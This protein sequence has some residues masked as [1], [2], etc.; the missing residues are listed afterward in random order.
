MTVQPNDIWRIIGYLE[1]DV[2]GVSAKLRDL[3]MLLA[4]VDLPQDHYGFRCEYAGCG[5]EKR[6]EALLRDHLW[7]VHGLDE[8]APAVTEEAA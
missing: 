4:A 7:T 8:Y 2:R 5:I 1:A 3:R 6:T